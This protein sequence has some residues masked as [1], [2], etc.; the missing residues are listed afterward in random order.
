MGSPYQIYCR[1]YFYFSLK[2]GVHWKAKKLPF[3][4]APQRGTRE[5][6]SWESTEK[7]ECIAVSSVNLSPDTIPLHAQ[8]HT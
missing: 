4:V 2:V 5:C 8:A 1:G 3:K 6:R 7:Q